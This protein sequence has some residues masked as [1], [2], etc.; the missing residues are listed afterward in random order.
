MSPRNRAVR[1]HPLA[2]TGA[3]AALAGLALAAGAMPS[4]ARGTDRS[5]DGGQG[6]G[7]HGGGG[8][9]GGGESAAGCATDCSAD[10]GAPLCDRA[11]GRCVACLPGAGAC[12]AGQYCDPGAKRCVPGCGSPADCPA[13][14]AC[15]LAKHTCVGC[16]S[17]VEC[18]PGASCTDEGE[19][20]EGCSVERPCQA[21]ATCCDGVCRDLATDARSC[22]LCG[23]ACPAVPHGEGACISGSCALAACDSGFADCNQDPVDGCEHDAAARGP[24]SCAPGATRACYQGPPGTEGVGPCAP[25]ISTCRASGLSWGPCLGQV[26]PELDTCADD[27][28][29]D[30]DGAADNPP[31]QDGDGWTICEGDCCDSPS[32]GCTTPVLVNRGAFEVADN[33]IDDDCD[34]AVD[35]IALCDA[36]LASDS[37][38]ALDHAR[39][40]DLCATTTAD[41]PS[42]AQRTWGVISA[43]FH[44]A[45]GSGAPVASQRSIRRGFGS[46]IAP[47]R[48]ARLAVLSTG[49]AAAQA[50]PNNTRPSFAPFQ[51]GQDMGTSSGVPAD[52]LDAN[53]GDFPNAP[54]CPEPQDGAR[55]Y[56]PV[57]L[58][59]RLRAPTNASSFRVS[60]FFLSSE[61]P[62]A[63]CSRFND[64]FLALLDSTFTP[65]S[66]ETPNPADGNLAFHDPPPAGGPVYPL[67]VNLAFGNTGLFTRCVNGPTGCSDG[68]TA[69]STTTCAGIEQLLGTGFDI[70]R[71]PAQFPGD[72][73]WCGASDRAG[74]GTGWLVMNG[75]VSPGEIMELRFVLWDTGDPWNDS[76]ALLDNFQ[77]SSFAAMPG[78][79]E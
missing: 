72:P 10:P 17:D 29:N 11:T 7:G 44:R 76:V 38:S 77:W 18:P 56:D 13:P 6:D 14:L 35:D 70:T 15:D 54:G 39:A 3:L 63:V 58:K 55:A 26:L 69:G 45:D 46:G 19:C 20:A 25:G 65:L 62:E 9:G 33:R 30:C 23:R 1:R 43:S 40:M 71:P 37:S 49:V 74:G 61:Y 59:L 51:G 5:G 4:C 24:C 41:P 36:G 16:A 27:V 53:G 73:G 22:G 50:A 47:L 42:R 52:W 68:A 57:M 60:T 66:G 31:D 75:N 79:R 32:D 34:G 21:G 67:G 8:Q 28:D 78:T 2:W 64:F 12:P 48:G